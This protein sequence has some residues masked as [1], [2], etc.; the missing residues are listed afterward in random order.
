MGLNF[1]LQVS[2]VDF[3]RIGFS[4]RINVRENDMVRQGQGFAE[5]LQKS[6]GAGIGVGLESAPYFP[7]GIVFGGCQS[8]LNFCWVVGIVVNYNCARDFRYS[9]KAPF[10]S[11]K[12]FNCAFDGL[13]SNFI[14]VCNNCCN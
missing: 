13:N 14:E 7:M 2:G 3:T 10:N 6:L 4:G 12:I 5:V 11:L 1:R 9:F 8:G